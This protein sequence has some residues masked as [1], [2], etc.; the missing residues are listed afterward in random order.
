M[1]EHTTSVQVRWGDVDPAGIVYYPRFFQWYDL[2]C[3]Q[4]FVALGLPWPETFPK[5][6]IVGVPIVE[7]GSKF[8]SP[9]RYGDVLTIR[10]RVAW[11]RAR[12]FRMEHEISV[13]PRLC[14]AGF[15]VRA[16]VAWP[17]T[18]GE[19]LHAKPIPEDVV[20]RLTGA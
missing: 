20:E 17:K 2:G 8:V 1:V 4:L 14:A 10:S 9:A 7:S 18:P 3:E 6:E 15:E 5:Y 19:R 12:T 13:G 11:V 16:W